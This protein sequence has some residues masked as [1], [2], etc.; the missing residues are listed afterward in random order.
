MEEDT[1]DAQDAAGERYTYL[2]WKLTIVERVF[3]GLV[4]LITFAA[5]VQTSWRLFCFSFCLILVPAI[6]AAQYMTHCISLY[7]TQKETG[8]KGT[9]LTLAG[10]PI[11]PEATYR[12]SLISHVLTEIPV[13]NRLV[14]PIDINQQRLLRKPHG[15]SEHLLHLP[16]HVLRESDPDQLLRVAPDVLSAD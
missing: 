12:L 1:H 16:I 9:T 13:K 5:T 7:Y 14:R 3:V 4:I 15:N 11:V 6:I 8:Y 10:R 2:R